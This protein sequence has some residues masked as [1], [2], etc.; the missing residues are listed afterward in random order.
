MTN[1]GTREPTVTASAT[2]TLQDISN[3]R[4]VVGIGRGDSARRTIGYDPVTMVEFERSAAMI[5]ELMNGRKV[6]WN[7]KE[8]ELPWATEQPEIPLYVAGYGPKA[9]AVA[10]RQSDGVIVQLADPD[11]IEWIMGQARAA[12]E[13]GRS[14]PGGARGDRLRAVRDRRRPRGGARP[15]A[16]VPGDGLEPRVRPA[17]ALRHERSCP[18]A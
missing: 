11:I 5:R 2:A 4:M 8:L 7:G 14:R 10:G 18:S 12:A 9:L 6:E 15:G 3:G 1:P 16:L 17:A 13:R